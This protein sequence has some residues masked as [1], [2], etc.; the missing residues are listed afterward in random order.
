MN[1]KQ[2]EKY[3]KMYPEIDEEILRLKGDL[4]YYESEKGKYKNNTFMPEEGKKEMIDHLNS[5]HAECMRE[6]CEV[7][8]AKQ[9]I[10]RG[11]R[12]ATELQQMIIQKR[13]WVKIPLKWEDI[14]SG[15]NY[16]RTYVERQ[17]KSFLEALSV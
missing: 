16:H 2:V 1:K 11:L 13:F 15:M 9:M 17:Y 6:L 7:M 14:A 5:L 8:R 3:L 12:H 4:E 10:Q